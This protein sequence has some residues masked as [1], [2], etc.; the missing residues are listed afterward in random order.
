[1]DTFHVLAQ[2]VRTRYRPK[3]NNRD[4][5][6]QWQEKK[7]QQHLAVVRQQSPFYAKLWEDRPLKEWR[8]FPIIDKQMMMDHFD[9]LNTASIRKEDAMRLALDAE[10]S[11]QFT[12]M[13]GE[14]TVGLSSGT[15]GNRGLFLVNRKERLTWAGTILAKVLPQ[16]IFTP[17]RIS[18]FLRA[19]SNLYGTVGSRRLQ[20]LFYDLLDKIEHHLERLN[21]Q[22][23]TLLVAPPSMLRVLAQL[24]HSGMLHIRPERIVAVAEVLD[25]IDRKYIE[26]V[27]E[28]KVH[29][30]YQ[31]TEG[32]LAAT[33]SQGTLHLNEDI[34]CIQKEY[35]DRQLGKFVPI[36]TDF[37][38]FTQPIVRY[39]L[40]DLLTEQSEPCACGSLFT[41]IAQIEGRCDDLF[42]F[43]AIAGDDWVTVFPDYISRA[44]ISASGAV[45]A[46]HV[47]MH[48]PELLEISL[49]VN[50]LEC[51][52]AQHAILYSL[53][54]LC[55]RVGCQMP[56]VQFSS[57]SFIPGE[58]KLRRVE[59]RWLYTEPNFV[60]GFQT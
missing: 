37:S 20:F 44:I 60:K 7:I 10:Q 15:S 28:S 31:C 53:Q 12:P 49:Q 2:Y 32:L 4:A 45:E 13:I 38:R 34:V 19:N 50:E 16:S 5:L 27:F 21:D 36:V 52:E 8:E 14:I 35:V 46:Y 59:R 1:M 43:P 57:Y 24:Q 56:E 23:P 6:A 39:R 26:Q 25:P 58:R 41:A 54:D 47:I 55:S 18:F 51:N 30:V 9:Q 40:N 48:A 42:Y 17:Q 3:F 11:R 29:Q 33:C 22:Q